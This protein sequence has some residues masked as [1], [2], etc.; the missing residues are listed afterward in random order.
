MCAFLVCLL[1]FLT[2][3]KTATKTATKHISEPSSLVV[4]EGLSAF[5]VLER[6]ATRAGHK[7]IHL[8]GR[9][10]PT[11]NFTQ[12][13]P[14]SRRIMDALG[15]RHGMVL[16]CGGDCEELRIKTLILAIDQDPNGG[17]LICCILNFLRSCWPALFEYADSPYIKL[18]LIL[19]HF[20][21][22]QSSSRYTC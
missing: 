17:F 16:G 4:T 20:L 13:H 14:I 11:K 1:F 9:Y 19:Y 10:F 6:S 7:I 12:E 21:G 8:Q 18:L 22:I 2:K 3:T 5:N 15:L